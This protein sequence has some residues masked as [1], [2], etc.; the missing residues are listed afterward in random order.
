MYF[1][2]LVSLV[3]FAL[4]A[5]LLFIE[6]YPFGFSGHVIAH[7][8]IRTRLYELIFVKP[9]NDSLWSDV[10]SIVI[11]EQHGPQSLVEA[12]LSPIFGFGLTESRLIV[13]TLGFTSIS[14]AV[15]WG[16]LAINRWFGLAVGFALSFA[17][18]HLVYSRNG[19]SEHINIY[20]HGFFLL[21]VA[22]LVVINGRAWEW[23]LL[24]IALGMGFYVYAS[25]QFLCLIVLGL[26][27][28]VM[29]RTMLARGWIKLLTCAL[30]CAVPLVLLSLP[31]IKN[32]WSAGRLIPVRTPYGTSNYEPSNLTQLPAL[33]TRTWSELFTRGSDPWFAL[34]NGSINTWPTVLA[35][36]GIIYLIYVAKRS[37]CIEP[38]NGSS[39]SARRSVLF[40]FLV[41]I[42]MVL[43]GGLPGAL[44]PTPFFRRLTIMAMGI[45]ILKG[46]GLYGLGSLLMRFFPRWL[47]VAAIITGLTPYALNEWDTFF[48]K[49]IVSESSSKNSPVAIIREINSRLERDEAATVVFSDQPNTLNK[50]EI[51]D[52]L[53]FD[54]GYPK[55]LPQALQLKTF[56]EI[57]S[58]LSNVII[59]IDTY[60]SIQ[61]KTSTSSSPVA[62]SN[63]RIMSNR[64]GPT[65]VLADIAPQSPT[66]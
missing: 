27:C 61:Q 1:V 5:R 14:L 63:E 4:G 16:S 43:L 66:N 45:D 54:L 64:L 28:I 40:C 52:I 11:Q 59:P 33:L 50:N 34:A 58:P 26:V 29:A 32:S 13:A 39:D 12:L 17:P 15:W 10:L 24:G 37:F 22:Q 35:I 6:W 46:A 65:H 60:Q 20:L 47:A 44:S 62:I 3:F 8:S 25:S 9:W 21:M 41:T 57:V 42:A 2:A 31:A 55:Q 30:S 18:H 56:S 48:F 49:A 23:F 53:R 36:P 51:I 19:D 38:A 7:C